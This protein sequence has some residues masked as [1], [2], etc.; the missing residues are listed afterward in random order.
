MHK[1]TFEAFNNKFEPAR[2]HFDWLTRDEEEVDKYIKDAL[3][4]GIF[5]TSFLMI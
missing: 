2:T 3:C 1:L 5:T 4:G